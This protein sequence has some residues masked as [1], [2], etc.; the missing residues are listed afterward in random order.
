MGKIK[1]VKG[2]YADECVCR[3]CGKGEHGSCCNP[4][5]K[6]NE[7]K[8]RMKSNKIKIHRT[9]KNAVIITYKDI[10]LEI[11]FLEEKI[12]ISTGKTKS[13]RNFKSLTEIYIK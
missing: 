11:I 4:F 7:M 2:L 5:C 1:G 3:P 10:P 8:D 12:Q 9:A 13:V 6:C